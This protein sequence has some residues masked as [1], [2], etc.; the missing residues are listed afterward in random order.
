[1]SKDEGETSGE[2][3]PVIEIVPGQIVTKKVIEKIKVV[4]G[5]VMPDVARDILKLV[6]VERH[7]ASDG[8]LAS[9]TL[10]S[11]LLL[12]P[13]RDSRAQTDRF[14]AGGRGRV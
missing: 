13:A 4:D 11:P 5:E 7:K 3:Y 6:V 1:L 14:R 8:R 9:S 10:R 2:S 12:R